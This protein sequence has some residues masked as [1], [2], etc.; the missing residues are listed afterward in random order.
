MIII[1]IIKAS[2]IRTSVDS[3][4]LVWE[5][6]WHQIEACTAVLMVSFT[7]FRSVF[8]AKKQRSEKRTSSLNFVHRIRTLLSN[9]KSSGEDGK[10]FAATTPTDGSPSHLTLDTPF[11]PAQGKELWDS[12]TG[13]TSQGSV[14]THSHD[15]E[16]GVREKDTESGY[17]DSE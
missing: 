14:I 12:D 5:L 10:H 4:D 3:F 6:F 1:A 13:T 7:A 2:G 8:I 15:L 17:L 11:R 9:R 16:T